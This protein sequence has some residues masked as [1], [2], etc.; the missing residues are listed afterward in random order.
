MIEVM[1]VVEM[2][3]FLVSSLLSYVEKTRMIML[4]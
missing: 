1:K 4:S 3:S 2:I